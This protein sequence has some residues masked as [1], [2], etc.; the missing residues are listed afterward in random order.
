MPTT[1]LV[2]PPLEATSELLLEFFVVFSRFE[3]AMKAAGWYRRDVARAEPDWNGLITELERQEDDITRPLLEAGAYLL[4]SP[5]NEQVRA[6]DG[7]IVWSPVRC[8]VTREP[9]SC[10]LK[11]VKR[12]RNN[13]FHGGKF[14]HL[15]EL[16]ER[17]R[18]LVS[19]SLRVL[20]C[21]LDVPLC[22]S[23][24]QNYL[25]YADEQW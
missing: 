5:P 11:S 18:R 23:I 6:S 13:L 20:E 16:S 22:A 14:E 24:R 1:R 25:G 3:Y 7:S 8:D 17:N 2:P 4:A 12:V 9:L 15:W 10:L 21:L 19:D